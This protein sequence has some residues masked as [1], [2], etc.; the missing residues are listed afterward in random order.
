MVQKILVT[1]IFSKFSMLDK[2]DTE[3]AK[4][5]ALPPFSS[6]E[7]VLSVFS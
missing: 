2:K 4:K 1:K 6:A 3:T 5:F 7:Q